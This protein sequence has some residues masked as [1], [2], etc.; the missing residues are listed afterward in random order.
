MNQR[1]KFDMAAV[2][3]LLQTVKRFRSPFRV[4]DLE[5]KKFEKTEEGMSSSFFSLQATAAHVYALQT[6]FSISNLPLFMLSKIG[7]TPLSEF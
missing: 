2:I 5:K 6:S 3:R 1:L 7:V 4:P